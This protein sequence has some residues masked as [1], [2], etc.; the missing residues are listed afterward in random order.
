MDC[1]QLE[2]EHALE[3]PLELEPW[4]EDKDTASNHIEPQRTQNSQLQRSSNLQLI[5]HA[6]VCDMAE[7]CS[8]E[9]YKFTCFYLYSF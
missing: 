8:F 6:G 5:P 7:F 9:N 1:D 2:L 4:A 3:L